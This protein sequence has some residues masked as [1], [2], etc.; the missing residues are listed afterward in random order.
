MYIYIYVYMHKTYKNIH[1]AQNKCLSITQKRPGFLW[2]GTNVL[3]FAGPSAQGV[4][5]PEL[6][7]HAFV[8]FQCS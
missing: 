5:D 1:V 6:E 4:L 3:K 7:P 8:R 2:G